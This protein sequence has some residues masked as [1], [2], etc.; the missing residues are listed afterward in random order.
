MYDIS[1][2][3]GELMVSFVNR[4]RTLKRHAGERLKEAGSNI[5]ASVLMRAVNEEMY[6][7]TVSRVR[8]EFNA[9]KIIS[10]AQMTRRLLELSAVEPKNAFWTRYGEATASAKPVNLL[11]RETKQAFKTRMIRSPR[12][13]Y[14]IRAPRAPGYRS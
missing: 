9:N 11:P 14:R 6:P 7:L 10:L 4:A 1:Q 3:R 8:A 2:S 5:L 13:K 12:S